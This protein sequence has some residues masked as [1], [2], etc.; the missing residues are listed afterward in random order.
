[1]CKFKGRGAMVNTPA[2]YW[3]GLGFKTRSILT[4]VVLLPPGK[5]EDSTEN[6]A[7]AASFRILSNSSFDAIQSELLKK[8]R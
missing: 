5:C 4:Y 2:S 3:G 8:R 7:T 1:M 6:P